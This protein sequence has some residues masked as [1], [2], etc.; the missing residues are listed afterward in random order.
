VSEENR[1]PR[2]NSVIPPQASGCAYCASQAV[3]AESRFNVVRR[4]QP[5][6]AVAAAAAPVPHGLP[7]D[8]LSIGESAQVWYCRIGGQIIGPVTAPEIRGAFAKGQIDGQASVGIRGKKDWFPIRSLPQFSDI[9]TGIGPA[10]TARPLPA[11]A[12][13]GA[14]LPTPQ[15]AHQRPAP[16]NLPPPARPEPDALTTQKKPAVAPPAPSTA[17]ASS[18][19]HSP[20]RDDKT[21]I[22]PPLPPPGQVPGAQY[23]TP[24]PSRNLPPPLAVL[25]DDIKRLKRLALILGF[26]AGALFITTAALL[27]LLAAG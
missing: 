20:D 25:Q 19:V 22:V 4:G 18:A 10:P 24:V 8:V 21:E 9:L 1:C 15:T 14:A 11:Q 12:P 3:A 5:F 17:G 16:L 26:V 23:S 27:G 13:A 6:Q 2:C 7:A